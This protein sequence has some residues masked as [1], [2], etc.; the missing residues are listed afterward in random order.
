MDELNDMMEKNSLEKFGELKIIHK[1][2]K[3]IRVQSSVSK[4]NLEI[5]LKD[6]ELVG[7]ITEVANSLQAFSVFFT[8]GVA[9]NKVGYSTVGT[10]YC[11]VAE[12]VLPVLLDETYYINT[13]NLYASWKLKKQSEI[14]LKKIAEAEQTLKNSVTIEF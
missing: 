9:Q 11:N 1:N 14:A 2:N 8:S 6:L 4:E 5:L 13:V 12:K 7:K 10:S 3:S